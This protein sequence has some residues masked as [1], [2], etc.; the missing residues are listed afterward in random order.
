MK[1]NSPDYQ[2]GY[3]DALENV[4]RDL[5]ATLRIHSAVTGVGDEEVLSKQKVREIFAGTFGIVSTD[6]E[7]GPEPECNVTFLRA[8]EA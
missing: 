5:A 1:E 6:E 7:F 3:R 4:K 2:R 8:P